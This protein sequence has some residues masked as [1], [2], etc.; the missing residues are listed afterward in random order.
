MMDYLLSFVILPALSF[1]LGAFLNSVSAKRTIV[2]Q[3]DAPTWPENF[4][5]IFDNGVWLPTFPPIVD[6]QEGKTFRSYLS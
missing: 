4:T 1:P 2:V 6:H 3:P 5:W